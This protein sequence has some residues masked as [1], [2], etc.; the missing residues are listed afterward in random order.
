MIVLLTVTVA[1]ALLLVR[2]GIDHLRE[3]AALARVLAGPAGSG[4]RAAR[5][6]ALVE[7]LVGVAVLGAFLGAFSGA[8]SGAFLGASASGPSLLEPARWVPAVQGLLYL[9]F[10]ASLWPR[11]A[12]GDRTDCGCTALPAVVGPT[13]LARAAGLSAASLAAALVEPASAVFAAGAVGLV[14]VAVGAGVLATLLHALPAAVDG[15]PG[16]ATGRTA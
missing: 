14:L 2:T 3:P 13:A 15:V 6:V 12:R 9:G 8:F 5:A 11:Y 16:V 1:A 7:L 10:A 4:L